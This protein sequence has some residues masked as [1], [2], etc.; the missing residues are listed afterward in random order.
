MVFLLFLSFRMFLVLFVMLILFLVIGDFS[1]LRS[2][3][4]EELM[5]E[6]VWAFSFFLLW[7]HFLNCIL[8]SSKSIWIVNVVIS[9]FRILL[10]FTHYWLLIIY[11]NVALFRCLSR[12]SHHLLIF[13]SREV[14]IKHYPLILCQNVL[15]YRLLLLLFV[16]LFICRPLPFVCSWVEGLMVSINRINGLWL[17]LTSLRSLC[18]LRSSFLGWLIHLLLLVHHLLW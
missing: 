8:L 18:R 9:K 13:Q 11:Y 5:C 6:M 10:I 3:G 15:H 12:S 16:Y 14:V 2:R 7:W 4:M 17:V 1:L